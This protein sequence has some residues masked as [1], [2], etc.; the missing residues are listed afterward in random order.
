LKKTTFAILLALALSFGLGVTHALNAAAPNT[1][2][3]GAAALY[4]R[5]CA[6][7]HGRDGRAKT[8]KAKSNH[9]RNLVDAEWQDRV[10]DERIY[11]VIMNG[12]GKMPGY[13]KKLTEPEINALVGYVRSLKK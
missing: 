11:N 7:C 12:K 1:N 9:A 2:I 13:G 5:N 10:S 3:A 4:A 8:P 6:S